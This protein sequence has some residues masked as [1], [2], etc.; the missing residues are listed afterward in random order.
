MRLEVMR[1]PEAWYARWYGNKRYVPTGFAQMTEQTKE[2]DKTVAENVLKAR[3]LSD[4]IGGL[5]ESEEA[6]VY[7]FSLHE[8]GRVSFDDGYLT[9][10]RGADEMP[11]RLVNKLHRLVNKHWSG[12]RAVERA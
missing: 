1:H 5:T 10:F 8:S 12:T 11:V 9:Q 2:R 6:F 7:R 3:D 4:R